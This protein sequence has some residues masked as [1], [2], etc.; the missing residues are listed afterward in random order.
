MNE[1]EKPKPADDQLL[2]I[3]LAFVCFIL[4][5]MAIRSWLV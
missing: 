1:E 3:L 2:W 4:G 5:M